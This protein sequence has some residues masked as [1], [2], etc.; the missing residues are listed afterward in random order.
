MQSRLNQ[1]IQ[2]FWVKG[3]QI[4]PSSCTIAGFAIGALRSVAISVSSGTLPSRE[5]PGRPGRDHPG[6]GLNDFFGP[7]TFYSWDLIRLK[8]TGLF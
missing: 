2:P 7:G 5:V 3:T 1:G 4:V 8:V 6:T